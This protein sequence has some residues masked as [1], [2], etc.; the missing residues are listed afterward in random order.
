[1]AAALAG[2]L[3]WAT[4]CFATGGTAFAISLGGIAVGALGTLPKKGPEFAQWADDNLVQKVV[5]EAQGKVD[6][7]TRAIHAQL[8]D[9][10]WDDSQIRRELIRQ[11]FKD[12]YVKLIPGGIPEIHYEQI[13]HRVHVECLFQANRQVY[14]PQPLQNPGS[15]SY[16]YL[17]SGNVPKG[18]SY[19]DRPR[20]L[21]QWN[22][23]FRGATL[24]LGEGGSAAVGEVKKDPTISPSHMPMEKLVVLESAG[25]AGGG[26]QIVVVLDAQ[27]QYFDTRGRALPFAGVDGKDI[28]QQVW[29]ATGGKPPDLP[30]SALH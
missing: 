9:T 24:R 13:K 30:T 2:N 11:M 27:N 10:G 29:K 16:E 15:V 20:P 1:V 26:G 6:A 21:D 28:L 12:E 3:I 8:Q 23:E 22:F 4:A 17:V 25:S 19:G 7:L 14:A 18:F 5:G